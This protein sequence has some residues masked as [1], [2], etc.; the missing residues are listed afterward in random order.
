V[1]LP[2]A[3][4]AGRTSQQ[5]PALFVVIIVL[6]IPGA[7]AY[8]IGFPLWLI[9]LGHR[10]LASPLAPELSNQRPAPLGAP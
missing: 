2:N 5:S 8:F 6:A 4:A 9:G 1:N 3:L 10:L 7:L